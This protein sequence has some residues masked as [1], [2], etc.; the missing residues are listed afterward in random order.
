MVSKPPALSGYEAIF[1]ITG[2]VCFALAKERRPD[3]ILCA[4][5][6]PEANG[7]EV[8]NGLK[9]DSDTSGIS[10]VFITAS[11]EKKVIDI[12]FAMGAKGYIRK[13]FEAQ[14]LFD[15]LERC[16]DVR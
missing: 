2:K 11:V 16:F 15:T 8:F 1:A 7:Y 6:I 9:D 3:I 14:E 5:L 4:I 10:F 13:P 12:A